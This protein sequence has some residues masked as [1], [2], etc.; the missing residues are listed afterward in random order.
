MGSFEF[1]TSR[2]KL[3]FKNTISPKSL[4][5]LISSNLFKDEYHSF[6]FHI[7]QYWVH[8]KRIIVGGAPVILNPGFA[9]V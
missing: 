6:V 4:Y 8:I 7:K 3:K 1:A 2:C 5:L 9:S